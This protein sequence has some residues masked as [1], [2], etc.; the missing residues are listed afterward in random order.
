MVFQFEIMDLDSP[1]VGQDVEALKFK[2]WKL[3]ELKDIISRWQRYKRDE[4]FWNA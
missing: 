1:K 4:D 2:E 3:S